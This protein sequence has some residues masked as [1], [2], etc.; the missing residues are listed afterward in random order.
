VKSILF[1]LLLSMQLTTQH[2]KATNKLTNCS[3]G[4]A[5]AVT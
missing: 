2:N 1:L 3:C 4:L 5:T